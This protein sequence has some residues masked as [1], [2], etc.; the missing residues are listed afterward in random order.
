M[1]DNALVAVKLGKDE[2]III[3]SRK[4]LAELGDP[5]NVFV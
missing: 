2:T 3:Y 1:R 5:K 4:S